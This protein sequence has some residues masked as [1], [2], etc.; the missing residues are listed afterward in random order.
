MSVISKERMLELYDKGL[1]YAQIAKEIGCSRQ[2]VSQRLGYRNDAPARNKRYDETRCVYNGLR[3]WLNEEG[4]SCAKFTRMLGYKP[5]S[6]AYVR[7][8]N[9][10]NGTLEPRMIDI[11]RILRVTDLTYEEAF[12]SDDI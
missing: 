6:N 5:N 1:N 9:I 2:Y 11:D 12:K 4:I 3:K 7:V 8:G 10:L